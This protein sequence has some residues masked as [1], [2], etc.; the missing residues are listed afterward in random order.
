M[1]ITNVLIVG[2]IVLAFAVFAAVLAWSE[3]Q[4]RHWRQSAQSVPRNEPGKIEQ[5]RTASTSQ[6]EVTAA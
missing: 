5:H 2:A 6:R 4:T 3:H 1:P